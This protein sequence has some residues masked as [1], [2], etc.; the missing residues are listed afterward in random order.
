MYYDVLSRKTRWKSPILCYKIL[1][2]TQK[3]WNLGLETVI[4]M[5]LIYFI[6]NFLDYSTTAK[7]Y[8]SPLKPKK[9]IF[10]FLDDPR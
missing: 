6:I 1:I 10:Y 9:T 3:T 5:A 8:E 2:L 7:V 4:F